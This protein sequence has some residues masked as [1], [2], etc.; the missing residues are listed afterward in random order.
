MAALTLDGYIRVSRIGG[1]KGDGY[2][3]P[4]VQRERIEEYAH[5]LGATIG[6]WHDLCNLLGEPSH[7][8][9]L[10]VTNPAPLRLP[11]SGQILHRPGVSVGARLLERAL[12]AASG[13]LRARDGLK[14]VGVDARAVAAEVVNVEVRGNRAYCV[15]VEQPVRAVEAPACS[16]HSVTIGEPGCGPLPTP[17]ASHP[18]VRSPALPS[19][20]FPTFATRLR[21][22][23]LGFTANRAR[24]WVRQ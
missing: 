13:V 10:S 21:R 19:Y 8:F 17:G 24:L 1:R 2:I 15:P 12:Q 11:V 7:S 5:E 20:R 18:I 6:Q 16:S 9:S 23:L 14:V 22:T 3:A 4:D